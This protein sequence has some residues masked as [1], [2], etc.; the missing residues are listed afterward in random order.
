MNLNEAIEALINDETWGILIHPVNPDSNY[1]PKYFIDWYRTESDK[2]II[3]GD[4]LL[5]CLETAIEI[6][7]RHSKAMAHRGRYER[8]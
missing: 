4:S 8:R 1:G 6:K 5:E 3:G 2:Y 7:N